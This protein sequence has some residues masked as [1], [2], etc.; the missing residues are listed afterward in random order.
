[1][2]LL[3]NVD[4]NLLEALAVLLEERHVTRAADRYHLSQSAM[5]RVLQ[6]L[7]ETFGDELLVRTP[8][9]YEPTRRGRQIQ[10]ELAVIL[11][12]LEMLLRGEVF[13]P[14]KA[15]GNLRIHCTDYA[16]SVLGPGLLPRLV[17]EAPGISFSVSP[18]TD[19]SF[20]D[21][22]QGRADLVIAGVIAPP[23]LRWQT[24]FEEE[25]VCLLAREHPCTAE[26]LSI[27]DFLAHPHVV[28]TVL[29][30]S[31][32]MV[33]RRLDEHGLRRP[34]GLRVP[35]FSA[36]AAALPGTELI[37]ALPRRGA[38][39]YADHPDY[40]IAEAPEELPPF[41]YGM[42][43]HPRVDDDPAHRWLR[44]AVRDA[45]EQVTGQQAD[46][47]SDPS[48]PAPPTVTIEHEHT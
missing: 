18:L 35:Y 24:L 15:T 13:D 12:R 4:L 39:P 33:E 27:G 11:P 26:R 17:R 2:T 38:L 3:R 23:S 14:A 16:T 32:T 5:S 40:R 7:R 19:Q 10:S 43:W 20:T 8:N 21:V 37:A 28:I 36:A 6:R 9:G 1:M 48:R 25:F 46:P 45:T 41:P 29:A 30:D 44:Q 47:T 22:E 34:T 31:Q 42:A